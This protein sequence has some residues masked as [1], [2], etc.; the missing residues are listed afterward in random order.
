[1]KQNY[2]MPP[3]DL[4]TESPAGKTI[5]ISVVKDELTLFPYEDYRIIGDTAQ[6]DNVLKSNGVLNI[7]YGDIRRT[8]ST[9]KLNYISV[10]I[11]DNITDVL[12]QSV[13]NLPISTENI[14]DML[15]YVFSPKFRK[16]ENEAMD[17]SDAEQI[18]S[19]THN[20]P[21]EIKVFWGLGYDDLLTDKIKVI[22]IAAS[23]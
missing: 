5:D 21:V 18:V 13:E 15:F 22:L 19:F 17:C 4:L 20:L 16:P 7:D 2:M 10:G 1:M 3:L 12:E 8:L 11:G 14:S 6:L 23:K 9:D